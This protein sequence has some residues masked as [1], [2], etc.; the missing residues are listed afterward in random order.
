[1]VDVMMDCLKTENGFFE[2]KGI[3]QDKTWESGDDLA[4]QCEG[5]R[6]LPRTDINHFA[7]CGKVNLFFWGTGRDCKVID[8]PTPL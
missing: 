8:F 7:M 6:P 2:F 3:M 5:M 1:M 4:M